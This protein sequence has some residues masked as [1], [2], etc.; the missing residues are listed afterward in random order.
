MKIVRR[1]TIQ[2]GKNVSHRVYLRDTDG[3]GV[4]ID[5]PS[6]LSDALAVERGVEMLSDVDIEVSEVGAG[7]SLSETLAG[8]FESV[9]AAHR[10]R[11]ESVKYAGC[12]SALDAAIVRLEIAK[13]VLEVSR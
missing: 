12:L 11:G 13:P 3:R 2:N 1:V 5:T 8:S 4:T 7:I 6:E 10:A 9:I